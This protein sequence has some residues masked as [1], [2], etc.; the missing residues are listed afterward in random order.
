M[1]KF[2]NYISEDEK[3]LLKLYRRLNE[4]GKRAVIAYCK[5]YLVATSHLSSREKDQA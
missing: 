3:Q 5:G 1:W 2:K 4:A